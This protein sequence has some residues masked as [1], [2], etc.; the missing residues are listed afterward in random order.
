M[1]LSIFLTFFGFFLSP[2]T[3]CLRTRHTTQM[4]PYIQSRFYR[5]PEVLL[6]LPYDQAIDMWSLGCILY[7]LHT[8][9]PIFNGVSERDQVYKL[10]EVL[11][12]P[13]RHMLE[14]GRK[15]AN[16]FRKKPD[17]EYEP[18][19]STRTYAAPKARKLSGML[20]SNTGGPG[21]RRRLEPGHTP[22]DYMSFESLL[23]R[24]LEY[25]PAKRITPSE[26]LEHD[27]ISRSRRPE[28]GGTTAAASS[29]SGGTV[30]ASVAGSSAA[31]GVHVNP[32]GMAVGATTSVT[33]PGVGFHHPGAPQAGMEAGAAAAGRA[34]G[35][36]HPG[37]S[38]L[39]G[40]P[41]ISSNFAG[42]PGAAHHSL[43]R[44]GH[45][46]A[47]SGRKSV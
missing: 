5:S 11:G 4:Y 30:A 15:A 28:E 35:G 42:V 36:A 1:S 9:D 39:H 23:L 18:L 41:T 14:K 7:E 20:G 19:K 45:L 43:F 8:G 24:M 17:G 46:G 31:A 29:A 6:G 33:G 38:T 37:A 34:G 40:M 47:Y 44:G 26:A 3:P 13:P 12:M 27:F 21:G 22:Q 16:F 25:D 32:A 10:I 2:T